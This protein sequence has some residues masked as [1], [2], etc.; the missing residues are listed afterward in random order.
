MKILI[1]GG[2]DFVGD[3]DHME[4]LDMLH[5]EH[6]FSGAVSGGAKGAD[7]YGEKWAQLRNLPTRLFLA[8]WSKHGKAAGPI[9]N[10]QMAEYVAKHGGIVALLPGGKGTANMK[11]TAE[12]AGLRV[13]EYT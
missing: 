3:F 7:A 10:R 12:K 2:R 13:V 9:R 1:A 6:V 8:N 5:A 11:A 4:W